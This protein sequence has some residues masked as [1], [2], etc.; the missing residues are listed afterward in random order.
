[1]GADK[2]R[3]AISELVDQLV[4]FN[5][6]PMKQ[7]DGVLDELYANEESIGTGMEHGIAIPHVATDRVDDVLCAIGTSKSGVP[8]RSLDGKAPGWWCSCWSPSVNMSHRSRPCAPLR[9][10]WGTRSFSTS[11]LPPRPASR[12]STSSRLLKRTK[13]P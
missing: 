5:E 3:L 4:Q 1:M 10:S 12:S 11:W 9:R 6:L 13:P 7:R 8:F 2:K